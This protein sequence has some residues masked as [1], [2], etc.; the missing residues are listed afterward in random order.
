MRR[1]VFHSVQIAAVVF[2]LLFFNLVFGTDI[3][4][5]QIEAQQISDDSIGQFRRAEVLPSFSP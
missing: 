4:Q 1:G 3:G 2:G 5:S